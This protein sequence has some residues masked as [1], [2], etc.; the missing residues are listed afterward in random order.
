MTDRILVIKDAQWE[1]RHF[2][3]RISVPKGIENTYRKPELPD[4]M[5]TAVRLENALRLETPYFF[6]GEIIAFTRTVP[7]LPSIY[8]ED[9]WANIM[10]E[11]FIHIMILIYLHIIFVKY[12]SRKKAL[13]LFQ[14]MLVLMLQNY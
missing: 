7:D 14:S 2:A 11:H 12:L 4:F 9:E 3:A 1:R 5:R 10:K 8:S 13:I 6:D